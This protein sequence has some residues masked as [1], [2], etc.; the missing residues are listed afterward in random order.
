MLLV[1]NVVQGIL[2][3]KRSGGF[4]DRQLKRLQTGG[5]FLFQIFLAKSCSALLCG[6]PECGLLRI[7]PSL[8]RLL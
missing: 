7:F 5:K 6:E 3:L 1:K 4:L 8:K 2:P